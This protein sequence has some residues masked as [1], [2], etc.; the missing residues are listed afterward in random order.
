MRYVPI[1]LIT[2]SL[3]SCESKAGTGALAGA[4]VGAVGGALVTHSTGGA[5]VGGA[6]G[7]ATGAIIGAALDAS[8]RNSLQQQSPRTLKKI[9]N[10]E[11]LSTNDIKQMSRENTGVG[12]D[13]P[14][15]VSGHGLHLADVATDMYDREFN[16]GLAS[17]DR[18]LLGKVQLAL[19]RIK[20]NSFGICSE[21][22]KPIPTARLEAIPYT[23]TC[24]KCQE[25]LESG[26][27]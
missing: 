9:D 26:K 10:G 20:E 17:N 14:V 23:E 18:E 16:L 1:L 15:Q 25:K 11:Q 27:K 4:G 2:V 5:L 7:A 6:I 24:L 13:S 19:K 21:C 22:D 8:D 3:T 12:K